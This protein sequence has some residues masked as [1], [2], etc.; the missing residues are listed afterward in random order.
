MKKILLTIYLL[1]FST[2]VFASPRQQLDDGNGNTM[3]TSSNPVHVNCVSGC[4]GGG[5]GGGNSFSASA[6]QGTVGFLDMQGTLTLIG[7]NSGFVYTGTS[8]TVGN[9]GIGSTLPGQKLDIQGT[10]RATNFVG[11][12]SGLT[13]LP[14]QISGLTTNKLSK[15]TSSTTIGDSQI[16]DD[17]TNVGIG[18]SI[19]QKTLDIYQGQ[20]ISTG[21]S[22]PTAP[23]LATG[24]AGILTGNYIYCV[25]YYS[26]NGETACSNASSTVAPASQQVTVTIPTSSQTPITGRKIY[27]S[28]SGATSAGSGFPFYYLVTTIANNTTTS[29]ADNVADSTIQQG[30]QPPFN[31]TTTSLDYVRENGVNVQTSFVG[32]NNTTL[33]YNAMRTI[34]LANDGQGWDNTALGANALRAPTDP[35]RNTA[36]GGS[37]LFACTNCY[38]N[39]FVGYLAGGVIGGGQLNSGV[40]QRAVGVV[41]NGDGN[42]GFG[43]YTFHGLGELLSTGG[44]NSKSISAF[45]D[46]SGSVAGTVIATT[47]TAHNYITGD[48]IR[49][50]GT[51][52]Y[53]GEYTITVTDTTH[54]Y[55]TSTFYS[56]ESIGSSTWG[57][58]A[59]SDWNTAVGEYAGERLSNGSNNTFIGRQAGWL[60]GTSYIGQYMTVIGANALAQQDNAM[61]LGGITSTDRVNLG[62]NVHKPIYNFTLGAD[63][64]ETIGVDRN[65]TSS[66]NGQSLSIRAGGATADGS[67]SVL[68]VAPTAGGTGY[69]MGEIL[70]ITTGGSGG[71]A[72]ISEV[73]SGVVTKVVLWAEGS[74]YTTGTGKST[75]GGSGSGCTVNITTV[76]ASTD[77]NG[78]DL[79]LYSGISTG[80]GK[81]AIHLFTNPAGST[82]VTDTIPT[83]QLTILSSGNVGIGSI[84]PAAVLDVNGSV[85][86]TAFIGNGSGLTGLSTGSGTVSSG[87]IGQSAIYTGTTTVGA[88][89]IMTDTGT[90]IGIGSIAPTQKLDIFGT[91]KATAFN[92]MGITS[93]TTSSTLTVADGKTFTANNTLTLSGTDGSTLNVG[94]AGT[95]GTAAYTASTAYAAA[96]APGASTYRSV[97]VNSTGG[98]TAGTNPT[99]FSGYGLSDT[100]A[101][102]ITA[103]T[104]EV[105]TGKLVFNAAPNFTGNVGIGTVTPGQVL[106]IA[107]NARVTSTNSLIV[108]SDNTA[109][110]SASAATNADILFKTN[111]LTRVS[112]VNGGNVGIGSTNPQFAL[113]VNGTAIFGGS[114]NVYIGGNVG[115]GSTNPGSPLDVNGSVR[116]LSSGT[117]TT[118][119]KCVGG[120][121]AGIIQTSAC[122]LCPAGTC[123]QMNGC[124]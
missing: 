109:S 24:A 73:A 124:F 116:A 32:N 18:T 43:Y 34:S 50:R 103:I 35:Q 117:C 9:V 71:Q 67:I 51:K 63:V 52:N 23:T 25:T 1:F 30:K 61:V 33:G 62:I 81:S 14:A 3:G 70:S 80:T 79:N 40:G 84:F 27:R 48:A 53:D 15:A 22:A 64:A 60:N 102:L 59:T 45:A 86:A 11:N 54:F 77:K 87:T 19:P 107:G 93:P 28:L 12:G 56:T 58:L 104:D 29:F 47:T 13:N 98:V 85:R 96:G 41:K 100:S 55:F 20:T 105:G 91:V 72:K 17:G 49:I 115:I 78:G 113:D 74:G 123:T 5:G 106:D 42:S 10:V 119:Y 95:L 37:A 89:S 121:D 110:I 118:L 88:S 82:G 112:I 94:T 65:L 111:S 114:G 76:R 31:N 2:L 99:T 26:A 75:S 92:R 97:T 83:E 4:S 68:N 8:S 46:N 16:F 122:N 90:N 101:N 39:S 69:K 38:Q 57:D 21:L 120:V 108:G 66:S 36:V 44:T 7:G 6:S